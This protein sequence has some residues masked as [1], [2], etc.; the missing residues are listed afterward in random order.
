VLS[1]Q[2]QSNQ[3]KTAKTASD[4]ASTKGTVHLL[5]DVESTGEVWCDIHHLVELR[6]AHLGL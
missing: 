3:K 2:P 5:P 1:A 4:V 6:E